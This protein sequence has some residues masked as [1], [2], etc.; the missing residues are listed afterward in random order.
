[1]Y[2]VNNERHFNTLRTCR[3]DGSPVNLL[4]SR[5]IAQAVSNWILTAEDRL[6][7]QVGPCGICGRQSGTGTGFSP[8]PSVFPCQYHPTA[9]PYSLV[10]CGM[11]NGSVRD[12]SSTET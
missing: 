3:W 4:V 8:G 12:R 1:M 6:R 9:A 5:V 2:F 10:I 7:A 11:D